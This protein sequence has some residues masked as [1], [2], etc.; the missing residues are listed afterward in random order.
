M[1]LRRIHP[2]SQSEPSRG[3]Q[4]FC[5]ASIDDDLGGNVTWLLVKRALVLPFGGPTERLDSSAGP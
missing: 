5:E 3:T 4:E 2:G 1:F